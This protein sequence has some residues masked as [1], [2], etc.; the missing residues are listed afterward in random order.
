[1]TRGLAWDL[2]WSDNASVRLPSLVGLL[3]SANTPL[4]VGDKGT[5]E[6]EDSPCRERSVLKHTHLYTGRSAMSADSAHCHTAL[7]PPPHLVSCLSQP[8]AKKDKRPNLEI[9]DPPGLLSARG[10]LETDQMGCKFHFCELVRKEGENQQN[11]SIRTNCLWFESLNGMNKGVQPLSYLSTIDYLIRNQVSVHPR[12][13]LWEAWRMHGLPVNEYAHGKKN[14][15]R[16]QS[17]DSGKGCTIMGFSSEF[18][19]S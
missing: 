4:W 6:L 7:T 9:P 16:F 1:M 13:E 12:Q 18:S 15:G 19:F 5:P 10:D 3:S 8:P 17:T 2:M 14:E 11:K